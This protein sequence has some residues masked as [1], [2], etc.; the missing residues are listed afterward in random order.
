MMSYWHGRGFVPTGVWGGGGGKIHAKKKQE[1]DE[2]IS[3]VAAGLWESGR[4]AV[5]K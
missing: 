5:V 3:L 4:S 1:I 2:R